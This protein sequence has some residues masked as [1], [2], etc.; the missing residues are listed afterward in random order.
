MS[1]KNTALKSKMIQ[2]SKADMALLKLE[3]LCREAGGD[4]NTPEGY[5]AG[6]KLEAD[7]RSAHLNRIREQLP[8]VV[9]AGLKKRMKPAALDKLKEETIDM[10]EVMIDIEEN[11]L[12]L[13]S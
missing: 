10:E 11:R 1:K 9:L 2:F 5:K 4:I 7:K 13:M 12:R 3:A 6:L 8:T